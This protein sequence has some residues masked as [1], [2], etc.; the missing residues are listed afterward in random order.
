M[1]SNVKLRLCAAAVIANG[2]LALSAIAPSSARA[3]ACSDHDR[4]FCDVCGASL[5]PTV[6]GC[7]LNASCINNLPPGCS[8]SEFCIY[9]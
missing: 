1:N 6:P 8:I 3:S 7:T 9:S 2:I 4:A 5:C